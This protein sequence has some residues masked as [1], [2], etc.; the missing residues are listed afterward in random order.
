LIPRS[1][2]ENYLSKIVDNDDWGISL[3]IFVLIEKQ[4]GKMSIDWFASEYNHKLPRFYS[5][6][7]HPSSQGVDAFT[8]S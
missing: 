1:L 3:E 4:F 6:F 2:N 5:K 7:W 8:V